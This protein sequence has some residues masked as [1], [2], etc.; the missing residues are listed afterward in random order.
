MHVV[1]FQRKSHKG[2]TIMDYF[3]VYLVL[4]LDYLSTATFISSIVAGIVF[5]IVVLV[6][7]VNQ[8]NERDR[9]LTKPWLKPT[10]IIFCI[11]MFLGSMIPNTK[12]AAVV[13]CLPKIINNKQ[14]K[15]IPDNL[16]RLANAWIDEA[17]DK[18]EKV[19]PKNPT[20]DTNST[21]EN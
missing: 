4:R 15:K 2:D 7:A 8:K 3:L 12:Q 16:L 17:A 21:S 19:I 18:A 20:N 13:Y 1:D 10:A 6:F 11:F 9:E 14:A 5:L